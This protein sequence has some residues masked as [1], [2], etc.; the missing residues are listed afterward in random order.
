M[1]GLQGREPGEWERAGVHKTHRCRREGG[2]ALPH[3]NQLGLRPA[4]VAKQGSDLVTGRKRRDIRTAPLDGPGEVEA[5]R[6]GL[7]PPPG[8]RH[9]TA[10]QAQ[11]CAVDARGSD[12]HE[13][14]VAAGVAGVRNVVDQHLLRA[15]RPAEAHRPHELGGPATMNGER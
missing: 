1:Q 8:G 15:P 4:A 3:T 7:P 13:Y 12:S 9:A 11:V 10:P 5:E 6:K 2:S 14:L